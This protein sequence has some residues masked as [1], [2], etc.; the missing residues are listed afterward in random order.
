MAVQ[1][2]WRGLVYRGGPWWFR[3]LVRILLLAICVGCAFVSYNREVGGD[4]LIVP[5]VSRGVRAQIADEIVKIHVE[6]GD[7]VEAGQ[8]LATLAVR[9]EK[10]SVAVTEAALGKAKADLELLRTGAR[11]E[12]ILIAEEEVN[13]ATVELEFARSELKR[14]KDLEKKGAAST[15][16][17]DKAKQRFELAEKELSTARE[18]LERVKSGA[19]EEEIIAA[20]A[21]VER[22]EAQLEHSKELVSLG[23]IKTPIAGRVVTPNISEREGQ[24][25]NVGDLIAIVYDDST[26]CV[27]VAADQQAALLVEPDMPAS[28][29]LH[30]TNGCLMTGRVTAVSPSL[31]GE[32]QFGVE[33]IRTD[34]E[35]WAQE[36]IQDDKDLHTRIYVEM[37]EHEEKLRSGMTGYARITVDSGR[38][39]EAL[40][41][42]IQ[43]F[44][45]VEV[46]SW[47]P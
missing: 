22:I 46:W 11:P 32:A 27:E 37:D 8:I 4:C 18:N 35:T 38:L 33:R 44:F 29:R 20:E 2:S 24:N 3:W 34:R 47:L 12:T 5:S 15:R 30:G 39:W 17:L 13:M 6:E 43:R 14:T 36:T 25:V 7:W 31:V 45:R 40:A 21:E 23:E 42:P 28:I 41:R 1:S 9:D 26:L 16:E 10:A 19:R